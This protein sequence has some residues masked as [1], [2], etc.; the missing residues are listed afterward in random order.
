VLLDEPT[1][2]LDV[3]ADELVVRA[4]TRLMEDRTV[5]MTTHQP[6][7]PRLATRTIY[8]RRG[9]ILE[10]APARPSPTRPAGATPVA[11]APARGADG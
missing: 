1:V 2:G 8:L 9:G 4:L 11:T 6:T 3:Y 5:I 7:L 10:S